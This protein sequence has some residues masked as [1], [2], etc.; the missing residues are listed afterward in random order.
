[1]D[2]TASIAA[3]IVDIVWMVDFV[4]NLPDFVSM[5]A[6][7]TFNVLYVKVM[8]FKSGCLQRFDEV[9]NNL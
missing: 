4:I 2:I 7:L 3:T 9:I 5:G 6:S 1:M 8:L